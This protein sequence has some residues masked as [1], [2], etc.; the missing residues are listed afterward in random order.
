M[1]AF[2]DADIDTMLADFAPVAMVFG[3]ITGNAYLDTWDEEVLKGNDVGVMGAVIT[4]MVK[5]S[6]WPG[7]VIGSVV[8]VDGVNY[9][10][11]ARMRPPEVVDGAITY[12]KLEKA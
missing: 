12:L 10:V 5:T 4:V 8:T 7:L 2:N 9:T 1:A 6:Q 11:R 3:S